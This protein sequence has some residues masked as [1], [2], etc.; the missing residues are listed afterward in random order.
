MNSKSMIIGSS[1]KIQYLESDFNISYDDVKLLG[2][3]D[4]PFNLQRGGL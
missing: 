2:I 1:R 4:R 3:R